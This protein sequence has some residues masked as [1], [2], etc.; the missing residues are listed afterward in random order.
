MKIYQYAPFEGVSNFGDL[1]NAW[2]WKRLIPDI[3]DKEDDAALIGL[4]TVLNDKLYQRLPSGVQKLVIFSSGVGYE[5]IP[6]VDSR[7]KIYCLRGPMSAKVLGVS[8]EMA[9]TDGAALIRK[10]YDRAH[11]KMY[12]F[13]YMPHFRHG[14]PDIWKEICQDHSFGFVDPRWGV[15]KVLDTISRTEVL[16]SECLH[17]AIVADALRVPWVPVSTSPNILSFKWQDWCLSVGLEYQPRY[18]YCLCS[19]FKPISM[20]KF[21]SHWI[22]KKHIAMQLSRIVKTSHAFLSDEQ[23]IRKLTNELE[24]RLELLR[25]DVKKGDLKGYTIS[26][27]Y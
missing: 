9:V 24:Q 13:A 6:K 1:L 15:E 21:V 19:L 20:R 2:L 14:N 17:G 3:L 8:K 7:W 11:Q 5:K 10:L 26:R 12:R 18:I 4:G 22:D 23:R 16:I 25:M 27:D